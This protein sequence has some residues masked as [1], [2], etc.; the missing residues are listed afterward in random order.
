LLVDKNPEQ[1]KLAGCLW[2]R[3]NI[4]QLINVQ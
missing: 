2:N 4:A 1:L 3:K